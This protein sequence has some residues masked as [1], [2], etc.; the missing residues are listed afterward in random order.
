MNILKTKFKTILGLIVVGAI[1]IPTFLCGEYATYAN[2]PPTSFVFEDEDVTEHDTETENMCE[3]VIKVQHFLVTEDVYKKSNGDINTFYANNENGSEFH[4]YITESVKLFDPGDDHY[5]GYVSF[6]KHNKG[7]KEEGSVCAAYNNSFAEMIDVEY[8]KSTGEIRIPKKYLDEMSNENEIIDDIPIKVEVFTAFDFN[9]R[10]SKANIN[11]ESDMEIH[12]L[13]EARSVEAGIFDVS[14]DI[15]ILKTEEADADI[16]N[17]SL[18]AMRVVVNNT[19]TIPVSE[20]S[21]MNGKLTINRSIGAIFDIDV[22]I[23]D[24]D[25]EFELEKKDIEYNYEDK[26][27]EVKVLADKEAFKEKVD[28]VVSKKDSDTEGSLGYYDISFVNAVGSEVEPA[29]EVKVDLKLQNVDVDEDTDYRVVHYK[30]DDEMFVYDNVY[31]VDDDLVSEIYTDSFSGYEI[32]RSGTQIKSVG[33]LKGVNIDA[34]RDLYNRRAFRYGNT[35]VW[36]CGIDDWDSLPTVLKN[37]SRYLYGIGNATRYTATQAYNTTH[38]GHYSRLS[39]GQ[40]QFYN[41]GNGYNGLTAL[42]YVNFAVPA[43]GIF[44]AFEGENVAHVDP[45]HPVRHIKG[46]GEYNEQ[47]LVGT[48]DKY[49]DDTWITGEAWIPYGNPGTTESYLPLQCDHTGTAFGGPIFGESDRPNWNV[50]FSG[51]GYIADNPMGWAAIGV[52]ELNETADQPYMVCLIACQ[53]V[54]QGTQ[55]GAG[56]Y[57]F[58]LDIEEDKGRVRFC[59]YASNPETVGSNPCYRYDGISFTIY[60]DKACTQAVQTLTTGTDHC[61]A[62]SM[63]LEVGD[64]WYKETATNASFINSNT[65]AKKITIRKQESDAAYQWEDVYDEGKNA[66]KIQ[67]TKLDQKGE[68]VPQGNAS[69]AGAEF[70]VEFFENY[71]EDNNIPAG[72]TAT[73]TWVFRTDETGGLKTAQE[74]K[75]GGDELYQNNVIPLGTIRIRETKAPTGYLIPEEAATGYV[76]QVIANGDSVTLEGLSGGAIISIGQNLTEQ[77]YALYEPVITGSAQV[78]KTDAQ[79]GAEPQGDADLAGT[80]FA[81]KN[82]SKESIYYNDR[83]VKPDADVANITISLTNG[84]Y[85]SS[86]L[87]GLAYGTY[88]IRETSAGTGYKL[89]TAKKTVEVKEDGVVY[90]TDF[91]NDPIKGKIRI[92]KQDKDTADGKPQGDADLAGIEYTVYNNSAHPIY[93]KGAKVA[94]G[95]GQSNANKVTTLTTSYDAASKEY[96]TEVSDWLP[97]G[98]YTIVETKTNAS[99]KLSDSTVHTIKIREDGKTYTAEDSSALLFKDEVVKGKLRFIKID[100]ETEGGKPQGDAD[101]SGIE[102]T[103][104][105]NSANTNGGKILYGGKVIPGH[106]GQTEVNKVASFKTKYDAATNSYFI[107]TGDLPYGTYTIKETKTNGSYLLTDGQPKKVELREDNKTYENTWKDY[108]IRGKIDIVKLSAELMKSEAQG[109]ASL[110]DLEF[111]V[112]NYSDNSNGGKILYDTDRKSVYE[113]SD[114][115]SSATSNT[116]ENL[117]CTL[118]TIKDVD[119]E[120]NTKYHCMTGWLPYGTYK[121]VETKTNTTYYLDENAEEWTSDKATA[122][123]D[124]N[125]NLDT[126]SSKRKTVLIR[127]EGETETIEKTDNVKRG[128]LAFSK[129]GETNNSSEYLPYCTFSLSL[130]RTKEDAENNTNPLETHMIVTD[131]TGT[132]DSTFNK[133]NTNTNGNDGLLDADVIKSSDIDINA[134]TW[135]SAGENG[136]RND[137]IIKEGSVTE[138]Q[139]WGVLPY[140]YY[141][142]TELRCEANEGFNLAV[143]Q[144]FTLDDRYIDRGRIVDLHTFDDREPDKDDVEIRTTA[145]SIDNLHLAVVTQPGSTTDIKDQIGFK[146]FIKDK[147]YLFRTWAIDKATGE[148]VTDTIETPFAAPSAEGTTEVTIP[149]DTSNLRGRDIVIYEEVYETDEDGKAKGDPLAVHKDRNDDNQTIHIPD[150]GTKA[151]GLNGGKTVAVSETT[152]ITD[153]IGYT[154]MEPETTYLLNTWAVKRSD[155]TEVSE[156]VETKYTTG[157]ERNG[158]TIA[159]ITV[160]TTELKGESIVIFEEWYTEDGKILI[161]D[162]K[163]LTD[164]GQTVRVP[165]MGTTATNANGEKSVAIGEKIEIKDAV[166]YVNMDPSN[167]YL[168]RS[169]AVKQTDAEVVSEVIETKLDDLGSMEGTVVATI[170]V[171]TTKLESE[172]IVIFEEW[173]TEDGS[174][175]IIEHKDI[176]YKGQTVTVEKVPEIPT[177]EPTE[178]TEP[179]E[180]TGPTN[181]TKPGEPSAP[182]KLKT[183]STGDRNNIGIYIGIATASVYGVFK[184]LMILNKRKNN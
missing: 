170:P 124:K 112:Y 61:T 26:D 100:K 122:M 80:V 98:T 118:T 143:D 90:N 171:D 75:V 128:D 184:T 18:D 39:D 46:N 177:T 49:H 58:D 126:E 37:N 21:Y 132:F 36:Y 130:F 45:D 70:T 10:N 154:N 73:R 167:K 153:E 94:T 84:K 145:I 63:D 34:I 146:G 47:C 181:P 121:I 161:A 134:G 179:S 115:I 72:T 55:E 66:V 13:T 147:N 62:V 101:L 176:N 111:K 29:N 155:G 156:V 144:T 54:G 87:S 169:W 120:G 50:D 139:K 142:L 22:Y 135:F 151:T 125:T 183:P 95:T 157:K 129:K 149:A 96:K 83:E 178:P 44:R 9:N 2:D 164:E 19:E 71:F 59:K 85:K 93:Y 17:L 57:K 15:P 78:T 158:T 141:R 109:G 69:L 42:D 32:L 107:D 99:Y 160:N 1:I 173:Y 148:Y 172:D 43:W 123:D 165:D 88:E 27:I 133:H 113:N 31:V 79:A 33:K 48:G 53:G 40:Y 159:N 166:A 68:R 180:P 67:L 77:N 56:I 97:Y 76:A 82:K 16:T 105:N 119:E 86:T 12:N 140:G 35:G 65:S 182:S 89:N 14:F 60:K 106:A 137:D 102:F 4:T 24:I 30:D 6:K 3:H 52:L 150:I 5:V 163:D 108:V 74:W 91:T 138:G 20:L 92:T 51:G 175:L 38:G 64:Y 23:S 110:E 117:V 168:L 114:L 152:E 131:D 127:K 136:T 7:V 81:V 103:V 104:Y 162:H 28:L 25:K 116:E 41:D 11:I 8:D 174:T